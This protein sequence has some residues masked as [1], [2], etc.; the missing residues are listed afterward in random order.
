PIC[1]KPAKYFFSARD[2]LRPSKDFIFKIP[3]TAP[4]KT[5]RCRKNHDIVEH[6]EIVVVSAVQSSKTLRRVQRCR[7]AVAGLIQMSKKP[8][9]GLRFLRHCRSGNSD[10]KHGTNVCKTVETLSTGTFGRRTDPD[11]RRVFQTASCEAPRVRPQLP[12]AIQAVSRR[13]LRE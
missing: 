13:M 9:G 6:R 1:H 11:T 2:C 5:F 12:S 7:N 3:E 10:V 4:G 8:R